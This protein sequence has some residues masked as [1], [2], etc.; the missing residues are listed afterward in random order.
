MK[1]NKNTKSTHKSKTKRK[2]G[3]RN[4]HMYASWSFVRK[5]CL[6]VDLRFAFTLF[7]KVVFL[8]AQS[9]GLGA[10]S[11]ARCSVGLDRI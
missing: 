7:Y 6:Q 8:P 2:N 1:N 9:R 5:L 10:S 4:T 3:N 11:L